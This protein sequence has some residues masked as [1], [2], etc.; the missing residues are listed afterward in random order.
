[1]LSDGRVAFFSGGDCLFGLLGGTIE[2]TNLL[3]GTTRTV[4]VFSGSLV[5][6]GLALSGDGL[7]WAQHSAVFNV[8]TG[9]EPGGGSSYESCGYVPLSPV[10]LASLDLRYIPSSP[11]VLSG[12]P[13]PPQYAHEP[14]CL[15]V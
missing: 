12:V 13:I 8:E 7:A 2:V 1:V 5:G 9:V 11:I 15:I 3:A 14:G 6:D 4:V 10:E